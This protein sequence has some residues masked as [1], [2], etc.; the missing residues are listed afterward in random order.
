MH[1]VLAAVVKVLP[2]KKCS[3]IF[4]YLQPTYRVGCFYLL[5]IQM[6]NAMKKI[7]LFFCIFF[8]AIISNVAFAQSDG[9]PTAR[10]YF[11][12]NAFDFGEL[13]Q[14]ES[15]THTF[16]FKNI[17]DAPLILSNVQAT[18]GC[19]VPKWNK[20]PIAPGKTGEITV[21]F[22]STGKMGRQNKVV[23]IYSNASNAQERVMMVGNVLPKE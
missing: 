19:T 9:Q 17:G 6:K 3:T 13:K 2:F 7:T 11:E 18:C 16:T 20:E 4:V 5:L 14:G 10:L 21:T 23:T 1:R 15:A 8:V 12:K 22:N